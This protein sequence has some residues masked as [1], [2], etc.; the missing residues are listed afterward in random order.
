[1]SKKSKWLDGTYRKSSERP[2]R[3]STVSDLELEPLYTPDDVTGTYDDKL[4]NPGEYPYTRGVYGSMYRG[5]LWTMRQFAGFGLAED[6]NA[7]FHFLLGQGQDGLSTAFDM[8]TLMGYDAD[9]E[10]ALGEVG[11][12][13]VSVSTVHDMATLFD[14]IPLD[15]VTTSMTVN[16]S[17]SV[18]LAMYLVVAERNG[19]PWE[20]VG[21][22]IQNDMLKEYIAQKEWICPPRPALRVVTDM[23]EFC[24]RKVPRW[25]AVSISGYHIR[26]AGSTAVQELAFTIADGICYVEEAVKR[27]LKVDDFA[28]RLSF[29]WNIHNDFL[30]EVAKLRAARRLWARLMKERFGA[31]DPKSMMLRTHAQTAGASLTAQQPL[32]NVVRV[33]IQALAGVLGGVQSLHTNSMDETL[34][35]PTEN[36]V[37]V[38]LRTQQVIAEET[39]VTNTIDPFGGSYAVEALTDRMEREAADYIRRI[40]E[41]GG[42]IKAIE[43]GYPQR[44]IAESAFHYQ[45]QLEQGIKTVVGVNKYSIPEEIPIP[46][47]KIDPAIEERQIQRVRKVKRERNAV[48]IKEALAR[49]AEAC[50]SGENLMDPICEAVRRDGTVGEISDIF[51]AEFGVYKDPA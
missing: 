44:E 10:R 39:G 3:F 41:M 14:R 48:A 34:A 32:N 16:C 20:R 6:T 27:G 22:T 33:A 38:A 15:K 31:K 2:I 7:R 42:M 9:H 49:V 30:E 1:M 21:G 50:R 11:R 47:L 12:E 45:R 46:T 24:A 26:E 4:G 29:F 17:A 35:L 19:I 23:I 13:G 51:R 18:L 43:T 37:M 28:P 36:A 8:P 5:R 40:D 25:H